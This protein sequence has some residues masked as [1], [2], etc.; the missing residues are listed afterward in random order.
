MDILEPVKNLYF[1]L[2][3]DPKAITEEYSKLEINGELKKTYIDFKKEQDEQNDD[4][5]A[6]LN[7]SEDFLKPNDKGTTR[8]FKINKETLLKEYNMTQLSL[9]N[10]KKI[11]FKK[12]KKCKKN[13]IVESDIA[14]GTQGENEGGS[15]SRV[16]PGMALEH[17][18]RKSL[19]QRLEGSQS[20]KGLVDIDEY[21]GKR[22]LKKSDYQTI[23]ELKQ[24][25]Q[26]VKGKNGKKLKIE[27]SKKNPKAIQPY[28]SGTDH[29]QKPNLN[30]QNNF[31]KMYDEYQKFTKNTEEQKNIPGYGFD[32][33]V[34][35]DEDY[36]FYDIMSS[37]LQAE[38]QNPNHPNPNQSQPPPNMN[39]FPPGT[40]PFPPGMYPNPMMGQGFPQAGAG[41]FNQMPM[42]GFPHPP[43]HPMFHQQQ[44]PQPQQ[45]QVQPTH[46]TKQFQDVFKKVKP[47]EMQSNI[48]NMGSTPTPNHPY[49]GQF[50]PNQFYGTNPYANPAYQ[51]QQQQYMNAMMYYNMMMAQS[52]PA[53]KEMNQGQGQNQA[54][55]PS[56][57]AQMYLDQLRKKAAGDKE[58]AI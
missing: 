31:K 39:Q 26:L 32:K 33:S 15:Y 18:Q 19:K 44:Q 20:E 10:Y 56:K 45:K 48:P 36:N 50:P 9:L 5:L 51:Q 54:Q 4:H 43:N 53:T 22:G 58:G 55:N 24:S 57:E 14:E 21:L 25:Q 42:G 17:F 52:M 13:H 8:I 28:N 35:K 30:E 6:F 46:G 11:D 16:Q 49:M 2:I 40:G 37:G 1:S 47:P 7:K 3:I 34:K 23:D 29:P 38:T 41:V 12:L 27:F